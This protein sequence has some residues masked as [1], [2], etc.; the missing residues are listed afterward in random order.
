[1]QN[2]KLNTSLFYNFL[3]Q[4]NYLEHMRV[5]YQLIQYYIFLKIFLNNVN[6]HYTLDDQILVIRNVLVLLFDLFLTPSYL[7]H[8]HQ[9]FL[10]FVEFPENDFLSLSFLTEELLFFWQYQKHFLD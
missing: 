7:L 8:F 4:L 2:L 9:K 3:L 5:L 6:N 1:M 10:G